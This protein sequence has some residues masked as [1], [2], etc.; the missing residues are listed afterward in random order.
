[1]KVFI[2]SITLKPVGFSDIEKIPVKAYWLSICFLIKKVA[3]S[4]YRL[5]QYDAES[6]YIEPQEII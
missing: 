1:M 5:S 3:P 4:A 6:A 2:T